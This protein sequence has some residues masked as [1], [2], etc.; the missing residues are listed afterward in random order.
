MAHPFMAGLFFAFWKFGF[1]ALIPL[2]VIYFIL[3]FL[4]KKNR[5]AVY[6]WLESNGGVA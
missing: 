5:Q 2:L 1:I 4:F 3:Y 6:A